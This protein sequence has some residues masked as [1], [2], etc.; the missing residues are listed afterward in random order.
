VSTGKVTPISG[1][2]EFLPAE[3]IVE[4][5][6]LDVIR[7]TFELHGF[8]SIETRAVEPVERLLGKGG[9]ADKEIYGITRL[10]ADETD[11]SRAAPWACT[12][13]SPCPSRA[14]SWRTPASSRSRSGAIRSRRSWRGERPQE[15]RYREFT[16][17]DID[18]VDVGSSRRT[19]RPRCRWSSPTSSTG[20]RSATSSSRSTTARSPQGF[21]RGMGS[22][23]VAGHPAHR[24]QARQDRLRRRSRRCSRGRL[25]PPEQAEQCLALAGISSTEDLSFVDAGPRARRE[26]P[27]LDEGLDALAAVITAGHGARA[28]R[29][30]RRPEDRPWAGLLH[31]HGLRDPARGLRVV[32]FGLL[33][34]PLRRARHRRAHH[35]PRVSASRSASPGCSA[36]CSAGLGHAPPGR[37][38]P[39]SWSRSP[40]RTPGRVTRRRRGT[41]GPRH[42]VRGRAERGQV[43]QA[44]PVCRRA[45]ASPYVWFPGGP[46]SDGDSVKD[47]R[48]GEQV[49]AT[50]VDWAPPAADLRPSVVRAAAD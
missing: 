42:T 2:L 34:R 35:L 19:S 49:P 9:D 28:R 13:T 41:A 6:F 46:E 18:V 15:G 45:A 44:D 8:A 11:S 48:S 50:A 17:C 1:F 31:R 21:Y 30:R 36:C 14:T 40:T 23:D 26:R 32:G 37:P 25:P 22:T 24:R 10:A 29:A 7:E 38:R 16:Q 4:Q 5:H 43:R 20:C 47:I 27:A 3:R 33:R 12:S 39:P